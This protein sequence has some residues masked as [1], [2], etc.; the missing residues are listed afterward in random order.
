[1][2]ILHVCVC[3]SH[4]ES[5]AEVPL[6]PKADAVCKTSS[7]TKHASVRRNPPPLIASL[8]KWV[9]MRTLFCLGP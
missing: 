5:R 7:V 8:S 4:S 2:Y 3:V 1:M 6:A 9:R